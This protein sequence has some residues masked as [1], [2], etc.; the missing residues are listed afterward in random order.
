[1]CV[2]VRVCLDLLYACMVGNARAGVSMGVRAV[3]H[4][5]VRD[6]GGRG[7]HAGF[8]SAQGCS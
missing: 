2:G 7:T 4:Q 1:M 6:S 8:P 5:C 3:Q